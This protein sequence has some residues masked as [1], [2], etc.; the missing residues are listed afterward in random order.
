MF[1]GNNILKCVKIWNIYRYLAWQS[2]SEKV[3]NSKKKKHHHGKE[4]IQGYHFVACTFLR[5]YFSFLLLFSS[6]E[7]ILL[8]N[9]PKVSSVFVKM[10]KCYWSRIQQI[11]LAKL[12]LLELREWKLKL[13]TKHVLANV[14]LWFCLHINPICRIKLLEVTGKVFRTWLEYSLYSF[15]YMSHK[16]IKI[17]TLLL[18]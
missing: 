3:D 4:K 12:N 8:N 15:K 14:I 17:L 2:L 13:L 7:Y 1:N 11:C 6:L 16:I 9:T 5:R 18:S 10:L